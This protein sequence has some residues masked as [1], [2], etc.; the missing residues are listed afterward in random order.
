MRRM[1]LKSHSTICVFTSLRAINTC[2]FHMEEG[3][4]HVTK[5]VPNSWNYTHMLILK[6]ISDTEHISC[7]LSV[8][9]KA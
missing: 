6:L 8:F 9:I 2:E 7:G 5:W 3:H 1:T 4:Q